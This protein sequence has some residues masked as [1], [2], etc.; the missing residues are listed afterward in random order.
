MRSVETNSNLDNYKLWTEDN[1]DE[2]S[3][4]FFEGKLTNQT[5]WKSTA[6]LA[7]KADLLRYLILFNF[8][9]WYLDA[10]IELHSSL[11]NFSVGMK[12]VLASENMWF[13]NSILAAEAGHTMLKEINSDIWKNQNKTINQD[14][15]LSL[16]GPLMLT[17]KIQEGFWHTRADTRCLPP[18]FF[19]MQPGY[20]ITWA[21]KTRPEVLDHGGYPASRIGLHKYHA[22]WL[23]DESSLTHGPLNDLHPIRRLKLQ[24]ARKLRFRTRIRKFLEG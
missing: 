10:D 4:I 12:L 9:G 18:S 23:Q 5:L 13:T 19:V 16:T 2:I 17:E 20:D 24:L 15:V 21:R 14:N 1:I 11:S 8:G 7:V 22:S 6:S 3:S